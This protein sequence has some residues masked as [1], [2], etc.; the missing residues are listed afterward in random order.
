MLEFEEKTII[1][2][3]KYVFHKLVVFDH[4]EEVDDVQVLRKHLLALLQLDVLLGLLQ[5]LEFAPGPAGQAAEVERQGLAIAVREAG[6]VQDHV[7]DVVELL[8]PGRVADQV[9]TLLNQLLFESLLLRRLV[10]YV[11]Q[12]LS[13]PRHHDT[14]ALAFR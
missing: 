10:F 13:V 11:I 3:E 6:L 5:M 1:L 7:I 14:L 8:A 9:L 12:K 4:L 2:R